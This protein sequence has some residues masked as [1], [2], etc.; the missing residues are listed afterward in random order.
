MTPTKPPSHKRKKRKANCD[1]DY[2]FTGEVVVEETTIAD[3]DFGAITV[4]GH[5][6][7][8]RCSKC[9]KESLSLFSWDE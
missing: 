3:D 5:F 7:V 9:G 8:S 1:H 6:T 4:T 2:R